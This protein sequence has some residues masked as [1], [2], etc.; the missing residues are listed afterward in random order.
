MSAILVEGDGTILEKTG[1]NAASVLPVP[2]GAISNMFFPDN[3]GGN[4]IIWGKVGSVNPDSESALLT[5]LDSNSKTELGF[6]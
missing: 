2:V 3:I 4:A 5:D 1:S 6:F